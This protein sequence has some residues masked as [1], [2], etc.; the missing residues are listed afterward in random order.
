MEQFK[1][2]SLD[3]QEFCLALLHWDCL[4]DTQMEK[5]LGSEGKAWPLQILAETLAGSMNLGQV[6]S[7]QFPCL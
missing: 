2:L 3:D 6:V 7:S 4:D 5:E 1:G